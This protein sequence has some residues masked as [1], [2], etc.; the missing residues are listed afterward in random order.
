MSKD[1]GIAKDAH[2]KPRKASAKP[3]RTTSRRA[4]ANAPAGIAAAKADGER[5][6]EVHAA[7][8]EA[9]AKMEAA[10][11]AVAEL[12]DA[13]EPYMALV[14]DKGKP[15]TDREMGMRDMDLTSDACKVATMSLAL[16][17]RLLAERKPRSFSVSA[18]DI[19]LLGEL[20]GTAWSGFVL[21][22]AASFMR[23]AMA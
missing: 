22:T 10:R 2:R 9:E 11:N 16:L 13:L 17:A 15:L 7:G 3:R 5:L 18:N 23:A 21:G 6:A 19:L 12:A 8:R 1:N 14:S 20:A 4:A